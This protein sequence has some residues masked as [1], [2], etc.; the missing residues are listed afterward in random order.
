MQVFGEGRVV[1]TAEYATLAAYEQDL[2]KLMGDAKY[3]E[4]VKESEGTF[5]DGSLKETLVV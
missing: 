5:V 2:T 3:W 4:L 1:W